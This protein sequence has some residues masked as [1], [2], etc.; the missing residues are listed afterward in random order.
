MICPISTKFQRRRHTIPFSIYHPSPHVS[1]SECHRQ[2]QVLRRAL[3]RALNLTI[4]HQ[5]CVVKQVSFIT[6]ARSLNAQDLRNKLKFFKVSEAIF[7]KFESIRTKLDMK[8]FDEYSNILRCMYCVRL[9]SVGAQ[10]GQALEQK[11]IQPP[12]LPLPQNQYLRSLSP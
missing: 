3:R 6:G 1:L 7:E 11:P 4:Q 2:S 9:N 5:G 8:I 12:A 10:P